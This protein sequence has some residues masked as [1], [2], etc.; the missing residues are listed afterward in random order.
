MTDQKNRDA[1]KQWFD[2]NG[3]SISDWAAQRG[4]SRNQ[5]YA[6]LSGRVAGKRGSGHQIAVALGLKAPLTK[7]EAPDSTAKALSRASGDSG[8]TP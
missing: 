8:K 4:F 7:D 3:I 5:V 1:V 6:V 2:S